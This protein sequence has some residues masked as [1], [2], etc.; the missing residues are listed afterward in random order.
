MILTRFGDLWLD[1]RDSIWSIP[2]DALQLSFL[3]SLGFCKSWRLSSSPSTCKFY[4]SITLP[5]I[6]HIDLHAYI[7]FYWLFPF[8]QYLCISY[9]YGHP[10]FCLSPT[11][12]S[13][14]IDVR[15]PSITNHT[16]L[17]QSNWIWKSDYCRFVIETRWLNPFTLKSSSRSIVCYFHTFGNNLGIKQKFAK[18]FKERCCFF[19]WLTFLL[20]MF[21][22]KC[23]LRKIF[24]KS[25]GLFW[26]LWVSMG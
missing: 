22:K 2:V 18:Y 26:L 15:H 3:N 5:I 7:A 24:P 25:S 1:F 6:H 13:S 12:L 16:S 8:Y 19:F 11:Y 9:A 21:S 23:F 10:I 4:L 17:N 14:A 20:Q